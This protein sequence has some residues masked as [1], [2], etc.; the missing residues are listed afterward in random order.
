VL[1]PI[2]LIALLL[3]TEGTQTLGSEL[4]Q[5]AL[6]VPAG[7]VDLDREITSYGVFDAADSFVIAYY[8]VEPDGLLHDLQ[9]RA[10][11]KRAGGWTYGST[12]A[13]GGVLRMQ[14][15]A[16]FVYVSGH[17]SPSAALTVV[18]DQNLKVRNKLDGWVE[19]VLADGRLVFQRSMTHFQPAH[20]ALLAIYDPVS[21]LERTFYPVAGAENNRGLEW[22]S[23]GRD[24]AVDRTLSQFETVPPS[25]ILFNVA[26]QAIQV[27]QDG[28]RP[29]DVP[30]RFRVVC[31]VA[32]SV[33]TCVVVDHPAAAPLVPHF[34]QNGKN[35]LRR[36]SQPPQRSNSFNPQ[37]T[38]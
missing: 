28:A 20:A 31:N 1:L 5:R 29:I 33:P 4:A 32:V 36:M 10:F 18:L 27:K 13:I 11:D 37:W 21:G 25:N 12:P 26:T 24:V 35:T 38:Q 17:A 15:A 2:L 3:S 16:G 30:Q 22:V 19:L 9:V 23:K 6:P 7:A 34:G 14:R 8:L